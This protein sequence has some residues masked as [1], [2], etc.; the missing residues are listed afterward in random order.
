MV[1]VSLKDIEETTQA[2]L[3]AHGAGAFA[4]AEVARAVA[5]AESVGNKICGLYYVESYCQQLRSGRVKGDVT[6]KVT[7][8]R[9][10]LVTV[11]AGFGFAQPAFAHGLPLA[12]EAARQNGI[13]NLAGVFH[14]TNRARW[15]D[16]DRVHQCLAHC[17]R[18]GGQKPCDW[19]EPDCIFGA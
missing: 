12:L 1:N 17:R 11:D 7:T 13:A 10:G 18:T 5:A 2:A 16:R 9:P 4:A 6:P 19:H 15:H 8:P 3:M 14:R